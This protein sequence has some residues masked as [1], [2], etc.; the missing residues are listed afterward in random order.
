MEVMK[1]VQCI[2]EEDKREFFKST[3]QW[4]WPKTDASLGLHYTVGHFLESTFIS[5]VPVFSS[6]YNHCPTLTV[7]LIPICWD[8]VES[9]FE[10]INQCASHITD[11]LWFHDPSYAEV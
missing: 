3:E 6:I 9:Y 8:V 4:A 1:P 2:C 11:F 5:L 10:K 7:W